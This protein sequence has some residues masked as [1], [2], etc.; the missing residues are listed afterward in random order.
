[1][2]QPGLAALLL[3][4][5]AASGNAFQA[6]PPAVRGSRTAASTTSALAANR[7][8]GAWGRR[9]SP[10]TTTT[11]RKKTLQDRSRAEAVSLVTDILRAATEAGPRAGPT[12]T[13][14]ASRAVSR[15]AREFLPQLLGGTVDLPVLLR[16]LFERLG[17]TYVKLGQFIA[18]SPTLFPKE[19]VVEFQKCL[20]ATEPLPWATIR[21]VM[22]D[23]LG[24]ISQTFAYMDETPL[25]SASI[26]QVHAGRLHTGED[27]VVKVQK[28]GIDASLKADLGFLYVA[29][30]VLEFLQPDWERTSLS[31]VA[32]DLRASMLEELD[33]NKEAVNTIEFRRFLQ[34]QDLLQVATAPRVYLDHTTAKVMTMER[35][36]GSSM[37]DEESMAKVSGNPEMGQQTII[38]AL[39][40]WTQSVTTM[41]WFHADVHAGNLLL[42][43]DGRVGFIDFG[44]VGRISE[45]V[46]RA[47]TELSACV[48]LGDS[49]GMARALCQMGAADADVDIPKF[50]R[51]IER[52]MER[53][54]N[55]QPTTTVTAEPNGN[56]RGSIAFD[57]SE[58][59]NLLLELVDVTENNGL[60]LPREFGL[61]V[62]QV[63]YFDRYTKILAPDVDV[64]NDPRLQLGGQSR[65]VVV[66]VIP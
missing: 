45:S 30:R 17:A 1:M 25:A 34:D 13:W 11:K 4:L 58:I 32:G 29:A 33:F 60:K 41:P 15:T 5:A 12:R 14:Q 27:V 7:S 66:E 40:V 48:A 37:L 39:N 43:D 42:L 61:L 59:T 38:T 3:L 36:Y 23:E 44:I 50:G 28:P 62:K 24:P 65:E 46:F 47:V 51:D 54:T 31:A 63:L 19:Y 57:E 52:V 18:S 9:R 56:V 10:S 53:I 49:E 16:T 26:A 2:R 20:D 22:E 35:L 64:M 6:S 55:V 21:G 8:N